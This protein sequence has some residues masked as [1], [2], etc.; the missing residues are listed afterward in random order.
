MGKCSPL[1]QLI[2]VET[3]KIQKAEFIMEGSSD[4]ESIIPFWYRNEYILMPGKKCL[5]GIWEESVADS[6]LEP[7]EKV[8]P[9]WRKW[10]KGRRARILL[11][12]K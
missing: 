8:P 4:S 9:K 10:R 5:G 12:G 2:P 1:N 6:V 3:S 11:G 7:P